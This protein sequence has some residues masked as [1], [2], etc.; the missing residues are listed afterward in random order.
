MVAHGQTARE[1]LR[2]I[3]KSEDPGYS[4]PSPPIPTHPCALGNCDLYA[5]ETPF[6]SKLRLWRDVR[7]WEKPSIYHEKSGCQQ[8]KILMSWGPYGEGSGPGPPSPVSPQHSRGSDAVYTSRIPK[9]FHHLQAGKEHSGCSRPAH[10]WRK[11]H[12]S[13][14]SKEI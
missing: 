7:R 9:P 8:Q 14:L 4:I 12:A 3:C 2:E 1:R 11:F 10:Y 13:Q 5:S 6:A